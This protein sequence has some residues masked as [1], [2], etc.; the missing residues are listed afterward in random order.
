[1]T[2][3]TIKDR[4]NRVFQEVFDNPGLEI[5]ETMTADAIEG[6]DSLTHVNLIYAT[7]QAFSVRF[8]TRDVR[9]LK[10][11]GDFITLLETRVG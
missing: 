3:A 10:N 6:W 4:L 8:T 2:P 9:S 11:V 1:M 7:E 5:D